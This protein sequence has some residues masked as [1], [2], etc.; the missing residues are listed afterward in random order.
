[1][2]S[3]GFQVVSSLDG[4]CQRTFN[5]TITS[6]IFLVKSPTSIDK[7]CRKNVTLSSQNSQQHTSTIS[8]ANKSTSNFLPSMDTSQ[9]RCTNLANNTFS[10][11]ITTTKVFSRKKNFYQ[12]EKQ[13]IMIQNNVL[14]YDQT[15]HEHFGNKTKYIGNHCIGCLSILTSQSKNSSLTSP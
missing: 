5:E 4:P 9:E 2:I 13:T 14:L 10:K 11:S 7:P 3:L 12:V 1:M 15:K 6:K 8:R